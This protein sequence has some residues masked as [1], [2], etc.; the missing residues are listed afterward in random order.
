[1]WVVVWVIFD[2]SECWEMCGNFCTQNP[3]DDIW[4]NWRRWCP[5][6]GRS[7]ILTIV[8]SICRVTHNL[9]FFDLS[10]NNAVISLIMRRVVLR[11]LRVLLEKYNRP[12]WI[13]FDGSRDLSRACLT[14]KNKIWWFSLE[15]WPKRACLPELNYCFGWS[16]CRTS[17]TIVLMTSGTSEARERKKSGNAEF[18]FVPE[19]EYERFRFWWSW[20]EIIYELIENSGDETSNKF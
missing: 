12:T 3:T 10:I 1:M 19:S 13:D 7:K 17:K 11:L 8:C 20:R 14:N 18:L 15:R 16:V 4:W 9:F 5:T 2:D 6:Y